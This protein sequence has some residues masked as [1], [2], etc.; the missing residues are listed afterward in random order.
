MASPLERVAAMLREREHLAATRA[1]VEAEE[2][3]RDAERI[4]TVDLETAA[5]DAVELLTSLGAG[6]HV[7]TLALAAALWRA[8]DV[9]AV[10]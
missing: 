5:A 2:L 1:R 6:Q 7:V 8:S 3:A 10:P 4:A 9:E